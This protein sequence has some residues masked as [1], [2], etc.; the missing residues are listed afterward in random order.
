MIKIDK[1]PKMIAT[2][3]FPLL[4]F[5]IK[6]ITLNTIANIPK[7]NDALLT[8]G[9]KDIQMPIIPKTKPAVAKPLYC[10]SIT[11][12]SFLILEYHKNNLQYIVRVNKIQ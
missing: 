10:F 11:L 1:I 7:T 2:I 8:I 9:I 12:N 5:L 6:G 3:A 4:F